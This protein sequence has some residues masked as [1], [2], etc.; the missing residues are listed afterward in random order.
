MKSKGI[1]ALHL[2]SLASE[3]CK[4]YSPDDAGKHL[5]NSSERKKVG[6]TNIWAESP[7]TESASRCRKILPATFGCQLAVPAVQLVQQLS[8]KLTNLH[9]EP[10]QFARSS[11]SSVVNV[12]L[13]IVQT[14]ISKA[15]LYWSFQTEQAQQLRSV[16][17]F[18]SFCHSFSNLIWL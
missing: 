8:I 6:N 9:I 10:R 2:L 11:V 3:T 12:E 5:M 4:S 17:C 18:Y 15:T 1:H 13:R 7:I 14:E 16:K